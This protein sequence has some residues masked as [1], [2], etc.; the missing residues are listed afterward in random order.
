VG[1]DL[2]RISLLL[3][4]LREGAELSAADMAR[5]IRVSAE[6]YTKY[7]RGDPAIPLEV[8]YRIAR[9]LEIDVTVLLRGGRILLEAEIICPAKGEVRLERRKAAE[10][11]GGQTE[12]IKQTEQTKQ[13]NEEAD[14]E[15]ILKDELEDEEQAPAAVKSGRDVRRSKEEKEKEFLAL[16]RKGLHALPPKRIIEWQ[17]SYS[18]GIGFFD[19]QHK[20]FIDL[21]NQLYAANTQGWKYSQEVFTR[22]FRWVL[23]HIQNLQ[24][25]NKIMERVNYPARGAHRR[26]HA[27]FIREVLNQARSF[28]AGRKNSTG[29]FVTFARD[30][31]QSH[32]GITDRDLG[33]YLI[34]LK[35]KGNLSKISMK[36]RWNLNRPVVVS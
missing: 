32:V 1:N 7:E 27:V 14:L 11:Q 5:N 36:V 6:Q 23:L 8:L 25:E 24:N 19:E 10:G 29:E 9:F 31:I 13:T 15:K 20:E 22:I 35:Q 4:E 26:E 28:Q 3:K 12:Q 30:W 33:S 18:T 2:A 17:R 21:I 16:Y 34:R